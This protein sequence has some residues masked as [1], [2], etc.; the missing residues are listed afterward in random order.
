MLDE[1]NR[2]IVQAM[3][4]SNFCPERQVTTLTPPLPVPH[5]W[6]LFN[7]IA[8]E[9]LTAIQHSYFC[10]IFC[11]VH[12]Q[13]TLAH[14]LFHEADNTVLVCVDEIRLQLLAHSC[15]CPGFSTMAANFVTRSC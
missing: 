9:L 8:Q 2:I 13:K 1:D 10:Q 3:A 15:V 4:V 5:D 12:S 11:K 6:V 14:P 7:V